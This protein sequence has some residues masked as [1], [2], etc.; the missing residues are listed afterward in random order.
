MYPPQAC[1]IKYSSSPVAMLRYVSVGVTALA[2]IASANA[3]ACLPPPPLSDCGVNI[4]SAALLV[5]MKCVKSVS[6]EPGAGVYPGVSVADVLIDKIFRDNTGLG[7]SVGD[8]VTVK[9]LTQ[10]TF[11]GIG[12]DFE[13]GSQW[14]LFA[15]GPPTPE[16]INDLTSGTRRLQQPGNND[17]AIAQFT[18]VLDRSVGDDVFSD[19]S[20]CEVGDADLITHNCFGNIIEPTQDQIDELMD[21]CSAAIVTPAVFVSRN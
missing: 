18:A 11:C 4:D 14:I 9:S 16:P 5:T 19:G 17:A 7:L 10:P 21:A 20:V 15:N 12:R 3:C 6:C 1:D 13:A 2:L 8:M